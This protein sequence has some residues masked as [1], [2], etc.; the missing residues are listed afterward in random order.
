MG[1]DQ[2]EANASK[3][4]VPA[5]FSRKCLNSPM[6][7]SWP[8]KPLKRPFSA[9]TQGRNPTLERGDEGGRATVRNAR[10]VGRFRAVNY[11][12][13]TSLELACFMCDSAAVYTQ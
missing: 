8:P 11:E 9:A 6:D 13:A 2:D 12:H 5:M 10:L 4:G 1:P 3:S 7:A